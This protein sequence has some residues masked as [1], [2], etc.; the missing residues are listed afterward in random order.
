[1]Y[2]YLVLDD[3]WDEA[4]IRALDEYEEKEKKLEEEKL[5]EAKLKEEKLKE[6]EL[7]EE[8]STGESKQG[9]NTEKAGKR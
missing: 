5:K 8:K 6:V 3:D 7:K 4:L 2:R 1:M 9:S